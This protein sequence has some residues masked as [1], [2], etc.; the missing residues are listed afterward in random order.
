MRNKYYILNV[1]PWGKVYY[2]VNLPGVNLLWGKV[3]SITPAIIQIL[4]FQKS[5][6]ASHIINIGWKFTKKDSFLGHLFWVFPWHDAKGH[7]RWKSITFLF[8]NSNLLLGPIMLSGL[9]FKKYYQKSPNRLDCDTPRMEIMIGTTN[10]HQL[11][12]IEILIVHD[13]QSSVFLS[14]FAKLEVK[15]IWTSSDVSC[16]IENGGQMK[17]LGKILVYH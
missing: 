13:I 5:L 15:V 7:V 16:D 4:A 1:P 2:I 6:P 11:R 3:Y 17:R 12:D 14:R 8:G 9:K 10:F